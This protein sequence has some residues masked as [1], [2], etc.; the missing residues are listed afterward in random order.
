VRGAESNLCPY[1]DRYPY[2]RTALK[3]VGDYIKTVLTPAN[4]LTVA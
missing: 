4:S 1:R 3:S 2:A